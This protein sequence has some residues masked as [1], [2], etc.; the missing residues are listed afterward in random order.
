[1]NRVDS[2][3]MVKICLKNVPESIDVITLGD[4]NAGLRSFSHT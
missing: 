2:V 4:L 1:M 3:F